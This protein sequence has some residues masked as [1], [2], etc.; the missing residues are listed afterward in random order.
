M[1]KKKKEKQIPKTPKTSCFSIQEYQPELK[2]QIQN[3]LHF[4]TEKYYYASLI[5]GTILELSW[6]QE[7][8]IFRGDVIVDVVQFVLFCFVRFP[9]LCPA[10]GG[11]F[12][13]NKL[14]WSAGS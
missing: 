10:Q 14:V 8:K 13:N 3:T 11:S 12:G 5:K 4:V 1:L 6:F 7:N 2:F 9:L